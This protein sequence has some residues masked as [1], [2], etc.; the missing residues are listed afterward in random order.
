MSPTQPS[1]D[2]TIAHKV[3][4]TTIHLHYDTRKRFLQ[5]ALVSKREH[6][7]RLRG[8]KYIKIN[9]STKNKTQNTK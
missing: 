6:L 7:R 8:L 9:K 5:I 4:R 3:K 2:A 1:W